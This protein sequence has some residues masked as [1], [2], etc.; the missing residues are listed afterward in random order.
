[1]GHP[2]LCLRSENIPNK[3]KI[4]S[5]D[6]LTH[7]LSNRSNLCHPDRSEAQRRDLQFPQPAPALN[8]NTTVTFVIPT[9]AKRSGGTRGFYS[10][11][12]MPSVFILRYR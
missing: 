7:S 10:R 2:G 12:L 9:G 5:L 1:M 6:R 3:G 11:T 4:C 8:K